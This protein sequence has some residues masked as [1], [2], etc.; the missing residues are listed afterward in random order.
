[1][2]APGGGQG[3]GGGVEAGGAALFVAPI[4]IIAQREAIWTP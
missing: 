3:F 2:R 1:M 4:N